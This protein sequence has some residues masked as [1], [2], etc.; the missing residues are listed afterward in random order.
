MEYSAESL[1]YL[2]IAYTLLITG[3]LGYVVWLA[4]RWWR[5]AR[6]LREAAAPGHALPG[7][8]QSK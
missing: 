5:T 6:A 7:N 1:R 3:Q 4:T 8:V 2:H